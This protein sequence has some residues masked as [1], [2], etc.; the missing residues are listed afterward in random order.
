MYHK[1]FETIAYRIL[2]DEFLLS[3]H[4]AVEMVAQSR[5]LPTAILLMGIGR[6]RFLQLP[7]NL[8]NMLIHPHEVEQ[9]LASVSNIIT[10]D[11]E[12]YFEM[13][14]LLLDYG[15]LSAEAA[16]DVLKILQV[17]PNALEEV[18]TQGLGL[19][20]VTSFGCP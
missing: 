3:P 4:S 1:P 10:V 2:K 18:K 11:W 14:K 7:G 8:G 13:S 19:L 9:T 12:P 15:G 16:K 6:D 5:I 20:A 17:I